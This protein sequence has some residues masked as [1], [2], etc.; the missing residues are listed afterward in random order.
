MSVAEGSLQLH[1]GI[2]DGG[3]LQNRYG[4]LVANYYTPI[5]GDKHTGERGGRFAGMLDSRAFGARMTGLGLDLYSRLCGN[6]GMGS[7]GGCDF[8]YRM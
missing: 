4:A 5:T 6:D 3:E 8:G 2:F 1:F 7:F